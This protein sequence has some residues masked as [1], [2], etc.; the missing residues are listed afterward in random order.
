MRQLEMLYAKYDLAGRA[1]PFWPV[2]P[3]WSHWCDRSEVNARHFVHAANNLLFG[4]D[5]PALVDLA[6]WAMAR[7]GRAPPDKVAAIHSAMMLMLRN[8]A[9][10]E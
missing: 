7:A 6:L 2:F 9:D 10:D 8:E 5:T 3:D 4:L 1:V